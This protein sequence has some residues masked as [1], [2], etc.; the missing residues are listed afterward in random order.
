MGSNLIKTVST[1]AAVVD[2]GRLKRNTESMASRAHALGVRLR[3]HVKTH[4]CVAAAKLQ[5]E[6]HFGGITVS[7]LAEVDHFHTA[8]FS[9]IT[10]AV[11]LAPGKASRAW[12]L[13]RTLDSFQVLIDDPRTVDALEENAPVGGKA[14]NVLIK[15]DCG[16]GR[17]GLLPES[18]G[19]ISLNGDFCLEIE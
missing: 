4:K 16:Y 17:A 5:I 15:V 19:L 18:S 3:P 6:G 10:Y 8:G 9:D 7:T 14:L 2:L 13:H 12:A 1:P 11:P